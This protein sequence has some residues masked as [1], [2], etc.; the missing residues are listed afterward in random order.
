[1]IITT[2]L[3]TTV[4]VTTVMVTTV[5]VSMTTIIKAPT[6]A[7]THEFEQPYFRRMQG[8]GVDGGGHLKGVNAVERSIPKRHVST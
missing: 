4:M 6:D 5:M 3:V 8:G 1:M 7:T 2:V